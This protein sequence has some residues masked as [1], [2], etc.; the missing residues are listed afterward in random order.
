MLLRAG[1]WESNACLRAF[2]KVDFR[3]VY[4]L[5]ER[6]SVVGLVAA[7]IEHVLDV[8]VPHDI[9]LAFSGCVL[10][11]EQRNLSLNEFVGKLVTKL[12]SAGIFS[13]LVKGQ[14]VAQCYERPLWRATG[15]V[16]LL[17]SEDNYEK[18]KK[19]LMPLSTGG[20]SERHYSKER[21]LRIKDN[22]VELHGT[23][24]TG[25]SARVDKEIDA[26]QGDL[27]VNGPVR[28]WDN[29]GTTVF[30]PAPVSDVFLVF[31]HFIKH[32]YKE[33]MNLRQVCDWCRL[34]WTFRNEIDFWFRNEFS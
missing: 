20:G 17:M 3:V 15:D 23:L 12:R 33:G 2:D 18:A 7:G 26:T 10:R 34:I 32:F 24:R 22:Y 30:L 31:T 14:G 6:Q 9:V 29:N 21:G 28:S 25:L 4:R 5:S 13:L 27:L 16:D 8:K 11:L 19:L 1:L